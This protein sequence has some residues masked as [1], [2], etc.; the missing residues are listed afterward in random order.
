MIK[1]EKHGYEVIS[2]KGKKLSKDNLTKAGAEKRL[3]EVEYFKARGKHEKHEHE[4]K[5][6]GEKK[7][8]KKDSLHSYMERRANKKGMK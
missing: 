8:E 5:K 4:E 3:K 1:K 6:H 2:H 7:H